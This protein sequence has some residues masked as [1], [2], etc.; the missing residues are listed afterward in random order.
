[1]KKERRLITIITI[2]L[3]LNIAV[4]LCLIDETKKKNNPPKDNFYIETYE[5]STYT[6]K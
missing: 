3:S 5:I 4:F 6:Q 2:V 1:M